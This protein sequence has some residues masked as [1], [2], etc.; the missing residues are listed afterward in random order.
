MAFGGD[1]YPN[2]VPQLDTPSPINTMDERLMTYLAG[3][4]TISPAIQ[5]R[6]KCV[7]P[8]PGVGNDCPAGSP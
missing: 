1:G 5:G 7:D 8:N 4:G 6:I 3:A 2:L